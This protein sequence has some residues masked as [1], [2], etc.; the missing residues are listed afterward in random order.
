MSASSSFDGDDRNNARLGA[1]LLGTGALGLVATCIFYVLAGPEAALPGGAPSPAAAIAATPR[2]AGWM[3][4]AGLAGMPSDVLMAVGA[5]LLATIEHRRRASPALAGWLAL[6]IAAAL[7][8]AVDAM[9]AMVL[10]LAAAQA[11]GEAAYAGLRALFDVLFSIGA[12]TA[13]GGALAVAWRT[14]GV[15]FRWPA[16]GWGMR[17]AGGVG[18]LA[19]AAHL[20]GWPGAPLIGPGI[21]M[22]ALA[23]LGGAAA[24]AAASGRASGGR[25][26]G[27]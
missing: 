5:L 13:G 3:R 25:D 11:G 21:A 8:I 7:F 2:A 23:A 19:S 27:Q 16:L 12:W 4:A 9:V 20:I 18:L 10:P 15:L 26:C 6:S 17:A 24:Y 1:A 22:L 14:D